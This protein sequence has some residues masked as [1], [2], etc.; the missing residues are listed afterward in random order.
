MKVDLETSN[1][2]TI[3]IVEPVSA[4][5]RRWI[6]RNVHEQNVPGAIICESR[7]GLEIMRAA[8]DDG[9]TLRDSATGRL[10]RRV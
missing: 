9:L 10:A 8:L 7:Y 2:S 4:R 5:G 6:S 3:V 1:E